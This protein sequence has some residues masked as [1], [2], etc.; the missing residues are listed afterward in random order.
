MR[1]PLKRTLRKTSGGRQGRGVA[2]IGVQLQSCRQCCGVQRHGRRGAGGGGAWGLQTCCSAARCAWGNRKGYMGPDWPA[3]LCAAHTVIRRRAPQWP[4]RHWLPEA[5][6]RRGRCATPAW[7]ARG[8]CH[9]GAIGGLRNH[10]NSD[11]AT[12]VR[13]PGR[14]HCHRGGGGRNGCCKLS[15]SRPPPSLQVYRGVAPQVLVGTM[16]LRDARWH[17]DVACGLGSRVL[18]HVGMVCKR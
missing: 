14:P 11:W 12:G 9:P 5:N 17:C 8:C 7:P 16:H 18:E 3:Q 1:R 4:R 10:G 15:R 13:Y 2:A 6:G